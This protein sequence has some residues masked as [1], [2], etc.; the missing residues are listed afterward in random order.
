[1]GVSVVFSWKTTR[2]DRARAEGVTRDMSI[3]GAFIFTSTCPPADSMVYIEI[4]PRSRSNVSN[5]VIKAHMKVLRIEPDRK[6]AG[7][8]QSG[9]AAAGKTFAVRALG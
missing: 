9:F 7:T 8:R 5:G 4:V 6:V 2:T 3:S 1:M